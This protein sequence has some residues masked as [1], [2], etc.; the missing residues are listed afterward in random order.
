MEVNLHPAV[1]DLDGAAHPEANGHAPAAPTALR[2]FEFDLPVG[3]VDPE[4]RL[5]RTVVLR[6]MTGREEALMAD[7]A[8]QRNGGK[9]VTDLLHSCIVR[10]GDLT[11][12]GRT[13]VARLY[14][15]DRNYL[16]L[17]LRSITFGSEL[18]TTYTC[19][20][21]N[22]TIQQTEDLDALPVN[23]VA[24]AAS[25]DEVY[26]DLEDGYVD[27]EDQVHVSLRL[28]LPTGEDEE[29]VAPQLR[30]NASLG[31]NALLARCLRSLGDVPR[32]RLEAMGPKILAD[33]TMS[34]RR[35][36]DRALNE[37]APGVDLTRQ[38]DCPN[39]G[40][41]FKT[42]MDLSRFLSLE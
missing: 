5:H 9:L 25:P 28:R 36:I 38:I 35:R 6:K 39:C 16:L 31:K 27:R 4:G 21:C 26:V 14:S 33:L 10:L 32:Q 34:D 11:R 7:R 18:E 12:N 13:T 42:T 40:H 23:L 22:E 30:K 2:T 19:P 1:P 8:Y 20:N 29:A 3:Y 41:E 24:D 37:H 17:K 15:A